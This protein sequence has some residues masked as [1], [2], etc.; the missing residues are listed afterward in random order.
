VYDLSGISKSYAISDPTVKCAEAR[1]FYFERLDMVERTAKEA[2][3]SLSD[4]IL[5]AVTEGH[6]YD[7]L[8]LRLDIP[9]C[10]DTYYALYR[11]FFWLLSK[12][13]N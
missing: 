11:R 6:S 10:K 3:Y 2:D 8:K 1:L 4:Y 7:Y 9:C 12:T 5:K 13:R